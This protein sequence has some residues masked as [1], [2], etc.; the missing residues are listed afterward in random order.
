MKQ[1]IGMKL[2]LARKKAKLTREQATDKANRLL[3]ERGR[4]AYNTLTRIEN[5]T[6]TQ[7]SIDKV[8]ALARVY[9]LELRDLDID[10]RDDAVQIAALLDRSCAPWESNPEP[11]DF[12]RSYALAA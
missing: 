2:R 8:A 12:P 11:A 1:P 5:G 6:I 9:R 4:F 7:P 3:P 10:L